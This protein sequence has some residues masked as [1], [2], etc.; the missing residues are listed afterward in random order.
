MATCG[1]CAPRAWLAASPTPCPGTS[2]RG[3]AAD[4]GPAHLASQA[5]SRAA[6]PARLRWAAA[7]RARQPA[8]RRR[9]R[10]PPTRG[11]ARR[12]TA[13]RAGGLPSATSSAGA[14]ARS[15]STKTPSRRS[16]RESRAGRR[17]PPSTCCSR[18]LAPASRAAEHTR[19]RADRRP[20]RHHS[21]PA[22]RPAHPTHATPHLLH[23]PRRRRRR[24][25]CHPR[26]RRA[27]R[28][29]HNRGLAK[30]CSEALIE[31][32]RG[33]AKYGTAAS[34][35]VPSPVPVPGQGQRTTQASRAPAKR[36]TRRPG[37][38]P[39]RAEK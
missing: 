10:A 24:R 33:P 29:P 37:S 11:C 1:R 30:R 19:H 3:S 22:G 7:L 35:A 23:P 12:S 2:S 32:A 38:L 34:R 13:P 20:P 36:V 18:F 21:R 9:R 5:R 16:S 28:H 26:T 17:Q 31:L 14:P 15:R 6:A 8:D 27:R 4:A 39:R 25:R